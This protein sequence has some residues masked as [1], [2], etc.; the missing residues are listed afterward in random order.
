[1]LVAH[2]KPVPSTERLER[3]GARVATLVAAHEE[4]LAADESLRENA[5]RYQTLASQL[6][7]LNHELESFAYSLSHDLRAP[8]R[9]MQGFAHAL[10]DRS[11]DTL[12][13]EARDCAMRIISAGRD[14]EQLIANLLAYSRVSLAE[15]SLGPVSLESV[16]ERARRQ[17]RADMEANGVWP[18]LKYLLLVV[19]LL[20]S[21]TDALYHCRVRYGVPSALAPFF[22]LT[23]HQIA[24]NQRVRGVRVPWKMVPA[25]TDT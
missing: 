8:L 15:V 17:L 9:T 21:A 22:W 1:L 6:Q 13:P 2:T 20:L 23:T 16:V 11:G 4:R 25:V 5:H 3:M 12:S 7:E 19:A 24:R 14:S 10:L 18:S